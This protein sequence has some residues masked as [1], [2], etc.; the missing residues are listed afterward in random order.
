MDASLQ[1]DLKK[2]YIKKSAEVDYS[3]SLPTSEFDVMRAVWSGEPP[4]TTNF[5]MK[6]IGL[7]KG[8]KSP[9]LISF[10]VRLEDRGYIMSY[11]KG[12]ERY[13]IPLADRDTYIS[14]ATRNFLAQYHDGSFVNFLDSL[15]KDRVFENSDIDDL[16]VWLK[17]K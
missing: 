15:F 9:T 4:L 7:E 14:Q 13:Y 2:E 17:K 10:L 3:I 11:K 16:L 5:L 6:K 8:W 12:K 1:T